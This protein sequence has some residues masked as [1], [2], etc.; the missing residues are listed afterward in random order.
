M[1]KTYMTGSVLHCS[2][3]RSQ[4]FLAGFLHALRFALA[5]WPA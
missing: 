2:T 1:Q 3:G 5:A 4:S